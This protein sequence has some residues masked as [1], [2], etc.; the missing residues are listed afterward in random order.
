MLVFVCDGGAVAAA[1]GG[2]CTVVVLVMLLLVVVAAFAGS[3]SLSQWCGGDAGALLLH[4]ASSFIYF[5]LVVTTKLFWR[6]CGGDAGGNLVALQ[7]GG[8]RRWRLRLW[9]C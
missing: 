4:N 3:R 1:G 6:W 8:W 5:C 9:R 7:F 2:V